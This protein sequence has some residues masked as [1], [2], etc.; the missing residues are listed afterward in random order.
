VRVA[1]GLIGWAAIV[2]AMKE[3][4]VAKLQERLP[5]ALAD[6]RVVCLRIPDDFEFMQPELVGAPT[7]ALAT[8]F[9]GWP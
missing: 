3:A 6:K 1:E 2:L 8:E 4:H 5:D 7:A 9:E